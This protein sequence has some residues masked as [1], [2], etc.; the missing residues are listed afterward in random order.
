MGPKKK[1]AASR[2]VNG[3]VYKILKTVSNG[4]LPAS[5]DIPSLILK[6]S[7]IN[8]SVFD[9]VEKICPSAK[10]EI[11]LSLS[12]INWIRILDNVVPI[13]KKNPNDRY[14]GYTRLINREDAYSFPIDLM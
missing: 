14:L 4:T 10:K 7:Y 9:A 8:R 3:V 2:L 1:A 11:E 5:D 13:Q 12:N 6:I